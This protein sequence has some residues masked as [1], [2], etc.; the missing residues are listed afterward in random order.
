MFFDWVKTQDLF[1][2]ETI[3]YNVTMKQLR[4][5]RQFRLIEEYADEM[6]STGI[7]LDN[8]TYSTIIT[9]AKM[10]GRFDR[11]VE[12]FER[13]YATGLMPDEVTCSAMLDVY[14]RL[15][16]TEEALNLYERGRASGWKPD[17]VALTVL[18]KIFGDAGDYDGIR[19][20]LQEMKSLELPP[21][22]V[23]YNTLVEAMGRAGQPGYA[24][25]L[26]EE[27][28]DSGICPNEKTL[29]AMAKI[30]GRSKWSQD[31][32]QL[33][34]QIKE[35]N[36]PMDFILCNA[37]LNMCA[38]L[39][40]V[41]QAKTLFA[42]IISGKHGRPDSLTYSTMLKLYG[43]S[44]DVENAMKLF[45]E[46]CESGVE[47]NAMGTTC[48][49]QSLGKAGQLDDLVRVFR[50]AVE[51]GVKPDDRL[52]GCLLS[53]AS[54][55]RE[56]GDEEKVLACLE[57]ANPRLFRF[58]RMLL[59]D[60]EGDE[61]AGF[62]MVKREF[63]SLMRDTAVASRDVFCNFFIDIC[64]NNDMLERAHALLY[65][66][67]LY[68]LY[69]G[70]HKKGADS[71]CLDLRTL[72]M[73]AAQTALEE[74][75]Q[76]LSGIVQQGEHLPEAL[77]VRTGIGHSFYQGLA[78]SF[79]SHA[80]KLNAPFRESHNAGWF[81]ASREDMISWVKSRSDTPVVPT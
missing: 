22:L 70:L 28:L 27:M 21:N 42:D 74:W 62:E 64:R 1:P 4:Y 46:L 7:S 34:K 60:G 76:T 18:A 80:K 29:T 52:C 40:L 69:P 10:V 78:D 39:G 58:V 47:L 15:G 33:W 41:E 59:E 6:I 20:V 25:K 44:G 23:L 61:E 56:S 24:R 43:Y 73:G 26:F 67:S 9:S 66:G 68:G 72:S 65:L 17:Q 53:V 3:F 57:Q 79:V 50:I 19:Y 35:K 37:L 63:K 14:G 16:Q 32:L 38:D 31:A 2:M 51:R 36:W 5:G 12:W 8:I 81:V 30:Y 55:R 49:I 45:E 54:M 77:L 71:W 11:A 75:L 48:L 13:M